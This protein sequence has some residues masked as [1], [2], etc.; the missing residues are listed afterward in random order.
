MLVIFMGFVFRFLNIAKNIV[1]AA[2]PLA[3]F[4]CHMFSITDRIVFQFRLLT[5]QLYILFYIKELRRRSTLPC[6]TVACRYIFECW[7][8]FSSTANTHALSFASKPSETIGS[9]FITS[10]A[11]SY[12]ILTATSR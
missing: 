1:G 11:N 7:R 4:V 10:L 12:E 3:T 9:E 6:S 8:R 5:F 2:I